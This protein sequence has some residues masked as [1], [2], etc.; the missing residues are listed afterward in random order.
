MDRISENRN[1][2]KHVSNSFCKNKKGNRYYRLP[3]CATDQPNEWAAAQG[4]AE[5]I[6]PAHA[7]QL[8][9]MSAFRQRPMILRTIPAVHMLEGASFLAE[10]ANTMPMIPVIRPTI[11][12]TQQNTM[13]TIP[14]T[15]A[16]TAFP[17]F[18]VDGVTGVPCS[19]ILQ[20]PSHKI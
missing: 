16:A 5:K 11:P 6:A 10:I 8:I 13:D 14:R 7:M 12:Y 3:C 19:A 17:L 4:A 20:S 2:W 18:G 1:I 15:N 9:K